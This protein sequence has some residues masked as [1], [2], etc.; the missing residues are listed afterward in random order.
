MILIADS[1]STKTDW[2]TI[3]TT[4]RVDQART[5]G[6]NPY[7][8]DSA[9]IAAELQTS[10][11]P[12]IQETVTDVFYYGTGCNSEE[13]CGVVEKAIRAVFPDAQNVP[14]LPAFSERAPMPAST[15]DATLCN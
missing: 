6:F 3:D 13:S 2:R 12:T 15:T 11:L 8:Q 1:G 7:Y 9:A 14:G 10:L 5:I 4:G